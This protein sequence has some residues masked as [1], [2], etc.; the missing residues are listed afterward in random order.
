MIRRDFRF[1][2]AL[3]LIAV[4]MVALFPSLSFGH[5]ECRDGAFHMYSPEEYE[6]W[7]V[8]PVNVIWYNVG[9]EYAVYCDFL[10]WLDPHWVDTW[11]TTLWVYF[12]DSIN[13]GHDY[14]EPIY[15]HV[16][17]QGD[18]FF[19]S[20]VHVPICGSDYADPHG[21]GEWSVGSAHYEAWHW[22]YFTHTLHPNGW[23][24]GEQEVWNA[25]NPDQYWWVVQRY[26]IYLT[27]EMENSGYWGFPSEWNDGWAVYLEVL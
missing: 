5:I 22:L 7:P 19:G 4:L 20:R 16:M 27:G 15:D 8:D 12:H 13:G 14:W 17:R 3:L 23:E 9:Y 18:S 2:L 1:W 6:F 21:Y 24:I 25:F 10:D 26:R 11:G